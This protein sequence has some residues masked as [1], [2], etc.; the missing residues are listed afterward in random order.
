MDDEYDSDTAE[1]VGS[2][3]ECGGDLYPDDDYDGV[4]GQCSWW[5]YEENR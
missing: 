3:D 4:C 1:P 2:C 5:L